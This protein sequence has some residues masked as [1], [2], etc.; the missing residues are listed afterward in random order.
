[1]LSLINNFTKFCIVF[2]ICIPHIINAQQQH[3]RKNIYAWPSA[4]AP[5]IDGILDDQVWSDPYNLNDLTA[6]NTTMLFDK[7][8]DNKYISEGYFIQNSPNNNTLSSQKSKIQIAYD[9]YAIYISAQLYD[10]APDSIRTNMGERDSGGNG[11]DFFIA[12]FDTYNTQQDAYEFVVSASGVQSDRIQG[13]SGWDGNWNEIWSSAVKVNEDGWAVEMAIPY[14]ALRMPNGNEQIWGVNFGRVIARTGEVTYWNPIDANKSGYVNQFGTLR[15]LYDLTPPLRLS[16]SPYISNV[17]MSKQGAEQVANTFSGGADI[18]VGLGQ[19]FTL[20]VSLVPDFSQVQADNE[21]LNLSA[22]EVQ[23]GEFREFFTQGTTIFNKHNQF[24]SRRIGQ[25][26]FTS[27]DNL[28]LENESYKY[29]P[30]DAPIVNNTK[31]TGITEKGLGIGILNSITNETY[32][33]IEDSVTGERREVMADPLTNFNMISI[34]QSLPNNSKV[35]VMNNNVYRGDDYKSSNVSSL[36]MQLFDRTNT[37]KLNAFGSLSQEF[38]PSEYTETE[39]I[40]SYTLLGHKISTSGGKVSGNW[41]YWGSLN[42]E[43]DTYNPN[44]MGYNSSNNE[45]YASTDV[46]YHEFI[47]T[48]FYQKYWLRLGYNQ[49]WLYSTKDNITKRIWGDGYLLFNNFW[50]FNFD[51]A[52]HPGLSY[53][54]FG[55]REE[56]YYFKEYASNNGGITIT[57]DDRQ[58]YYGSL[59]LS[60]WNRPEYQQLDNYISYSQTYRATDRFDLTHSVSWNNQRD[61]KGYTTT[62]YTSNGSVDQVIYGNRDVKTFENNITSKYYFTPKMS[63]KL[64]L[65]HYWRRV[66]YD[67]FYQLSKEGDLFPT[68]YTDI[69]ENG[70]PIQNTNYNTFD[71]EMSY[72]WEFL[73]GSFLT[74]MWRNE[75]GSSSYNADYN[76]SQNMQE[77]WTEPQL[78]TVS[79]RLTYFLDYQQLKKQLSRI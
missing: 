70:N 7:K 45:I 18:K 46:S 13:T 62:L 76:F 33:I 67:E 65:R 5:K 2:F 34:E 9:N 79:I 21:V 39:E 32:A 42:I 57:S 35:G 72:S 25:N 14:R 60:Y 64:R 28:L 17:A 47:A 27:S 58:K 52:Y 55:P 78:N 26:H 73:P 29:K 12:S 68:D 51:M 66:N 49:N 74:A 3:S 69:D 59:R 77:M 71:L 37:Y 56:G 1:M 23:Y 31:L 43:S 36:D 40:S 41:R 53:D 63:L 30:T 54:Y 20:D 10:T 50:S 11:G 4:D 75:L 24:Y 16:L 44:D 22:Y 19:S 48:N 6:G 8:E 38:F 61:E 15:G